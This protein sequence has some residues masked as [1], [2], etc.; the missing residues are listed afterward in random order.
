MERAFDPF[1]TTK[2]VG[3]GTGLGLASVYGIVKSHGGY[4]DVESS[5]G[6][7]TT[8]S[9]YFPGSRLN[10]VEEP[11]KE[12]GLLKGNETILLVDDEEM[13]AGVAEQILSTLGYQVLTA[14]CG[15]EALALYKAEMN[16]IGLVILDMIMPEMGGGE[17]YERMKEMNPRV[18]ALLAS[19]YNIDGRAMEI[20]DQG[21]D[22]FIQKPFRIG[23]LARKM[24]EILDKN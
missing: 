2:E 20:L 3:R 5:L 15:K 22:G 18:K 19:G 6:E 24:R 10:R 9:I 16:R 4:I 11:L 7:G 8:F 14:K 21:C 13:I 17:I 23:D 1:F 12:K